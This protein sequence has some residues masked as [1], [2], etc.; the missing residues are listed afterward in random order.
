[1]RLAAPAHKIMSAEF[2]ALF[3]YAIRDGKGQSNALRKHKLQSPLR[4]CLLCHLDKKN[5]C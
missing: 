5:F 4:I 3:H 1:M 2:V